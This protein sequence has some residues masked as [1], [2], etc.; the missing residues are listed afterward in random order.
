MVCAILPSFLSFL[1]FF[2]FFLTFLIFILFDSLYFL[3]YLFPLFS[4]WSNLSLCI[5]WLC[6]FYV[7]PQLYQLLFILFLWSCYVFPSYCILSVVFFKQLLYS[8]VWIHDRLAHNFLLM[9]NLPLMVHFAS[10]F[11]IFQWYLW[12]V[13]LFLVYYSSLNE[14]GFLRPAIFSRFLWVGE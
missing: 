1:P 11:L 5:R 4:F 7:S 9:R 14:V 8:Y 3:Q 12:M 6:C 2:F 10:L 13:F